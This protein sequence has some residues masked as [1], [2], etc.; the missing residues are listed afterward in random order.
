MLIFLTLFLFFLFLFFLFPLSSAPVEIEHSTGDLGLCDKY[1]Q[2]FYA[3]AVMLQPRRSRSRQSKP[4]ILTA[5]GVRPNLA[6]TQP[7]RGDIGE[8]DW[9]G[10]AAIGAGGRSSPKRASW[11]TGF[12]A[13]LGGEP[14]KNGGDEATCSPPFDRNKSRSSAPAFE[15]ERSA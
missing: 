6:R 3:T 12:A 9:T 8:L 14:Q 2:G 1:V 13:R 15:S 5:A 4:S 11:T 7:L 10:R